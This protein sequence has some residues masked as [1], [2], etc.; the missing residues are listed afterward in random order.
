[1]VSDCGDCICYDCLYYWS[2]RCPHGGC[3]DDHR[4]KEFPY[5][6]AVR[7]TW[8]N[9]DKPGEQEHWCRGGMF[10]PVRICEHYERYTGQ[11]I[12][13]CLKANVAVFQ[14]GHIDCSLINCYGCEHCYEEWERQQDDN[15]K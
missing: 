5:P 13:T 11:R 10:H 2:F 1:M 4:A 3:Y 7:K 9:W 12:E 15:Q 14:D 6:G 8:S